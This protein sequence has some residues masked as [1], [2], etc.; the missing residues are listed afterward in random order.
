MYMYIH[1]NSD[2][3]CTV[4]MLYRIQAIYVASFQPT[5]NYQCVVYTNDLWDALSQR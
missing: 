1:D 3:L 5:R 2:I 4:L